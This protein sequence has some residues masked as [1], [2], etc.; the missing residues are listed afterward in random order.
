MVCPNVMLTEDEKRGGMKVFIEI[1]SNP[2]FKFSRDSKGIQHFYHDEFAAVI[3]K[4]PHQGSWS[5]T[6]LPEAWYKI[7]TNSGK[8]GYIRSNSIRLLR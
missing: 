3:E 1:F 8:I 4:I 5:S 2:D 6:F 7:I